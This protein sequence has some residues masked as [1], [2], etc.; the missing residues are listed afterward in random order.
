MALSSSQTQVQPSTQELVSFDLIS[1]PRVSLHAM[2]KSTSN[3]SLGRDTPLEASGLAWPYCAR[4]EED[5]T[6]ATSPDGAKWG[7]GHGLFYIMLCNTRAP[8]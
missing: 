7:W 1:L 8:V 4:A 2:A 3:H 6:S 5:G